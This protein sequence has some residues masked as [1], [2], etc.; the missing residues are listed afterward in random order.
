MIDRISDKR[1]TEVASALSG[2]HPKG[3]F[4]EKHVTRICVRIVVVSQDSSRRFCH[5]PCHV[6]A[7]NDKQ[8]LLR[9]TWAKGFK[10]ILCA[11]KR[12]Q[13]MRQQFLQA[14]DRA[15]HRVEIIKASR[16]D[17]SVDDNSGGCIIFTL[18]FG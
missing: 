14:M 2:A 8:G 3:V 10:Y 6:K 5:G 16:S 7:L 9:R 4:T 18:R 15:C 1:D 12:H 11:K 17:I 13:E